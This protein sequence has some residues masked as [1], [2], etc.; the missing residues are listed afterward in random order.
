[1]KTAAVLV[2][3]TLTLLARP[4]VSQV[5]DDKLIVPG[6]RIGK[7]TLAMTFADLVRLNGTPGGRNVCKASQAPFADAAHDLT[8]FYWNEIIVQAMT[9]DQKTIAAL[10]I[11]TG[12]FVAGFFS[13]KTDKGIH[14]KNTRD[15][16]VQA[17]GK[18]TAQTWPDENQQ[19][20][21]YDELGIAFHVWSTGHISEIWVFRPGTAKTILLSPPINGP[22][23]L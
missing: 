1:M 22:W 12:H 8:G 18:P 2:I 17:Y 10:A 11:T 23:C 14:F 13:Y 16:I 21:I 20:L 5:P 7:W 4:A 15:K 3:L 19:N 6:V 9:V